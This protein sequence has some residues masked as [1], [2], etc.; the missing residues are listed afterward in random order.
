MDTS[1]YIHTKADHQ[2]M[3]LHSKPAIKSVSLL[4]LFCSLLQVIEN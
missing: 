1:S 2:W 4:K 3:R